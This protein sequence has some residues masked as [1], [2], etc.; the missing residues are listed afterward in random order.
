MSKVELFLSDRKKKVCDAFELDPAKHSIYRTDWLGDPIAELPST[1]KD[2]GS[3]Q[4]FQLKMNDVLILKD[5]HYV[6]LLFKL[7][8]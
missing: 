3:I 8:E 5:N 6:T 2:V 7:H 4:S 1:L